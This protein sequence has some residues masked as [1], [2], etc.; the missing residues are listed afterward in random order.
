MIK[1]NTLRFDNRYYALQQNMIRRMHRTNTL[2]IIISVYTN[3]CHKN[4]KEKK[5]EEEG[6][7]NNNNRSRQYKKKSKKRER[8]KKNSDE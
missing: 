4:K 7:S 3:T 6:G 1:T 8:E 5:R 2:Q